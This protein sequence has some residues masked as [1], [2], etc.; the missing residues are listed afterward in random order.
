M[1]LPCGVAIKMFDNCVK[2]QNCMFLRD[3]KNNQQD[4]DDL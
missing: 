2:F 1:N 3:K 4:G